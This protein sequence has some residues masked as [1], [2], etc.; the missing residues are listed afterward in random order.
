MAQFG[1]SNQLIQMDSGNPLTTLYNPAAGLGAIAV[2]QGIGEN[3]VLGQRFFASYS[4]ATNPSGAPTIL[5]LAQMLST[6]AMTLAQWQTANAPAPVY[7]TD[8]TYTTITAVKSEGWSGGGFQDTAGYWMP[9]FASLPNVTL[10]Q[11]LGGQG[12]VQVAGPLLGAYGP[13]SGA[14]VNASIYG[15]SG[16]FQSQAS[17][18]FFNGRAFGIQITAVSSGLCNV[19]VTSDII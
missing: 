4:T 7:W 11:L 1:P 14:T 12:F 10:A 6:S 9:N 13:T 18:T 19:L 2:Y 5:V 8:Q 15:A 17:A 3:Q 16:S